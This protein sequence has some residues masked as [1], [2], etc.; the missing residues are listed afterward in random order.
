MKSR[1][2]LAFLV[3]LTLL[4][5]FALAPIN[6]QMKRTTTTTTPTY[7]PPPS[8][9]APSQ[10]Q[11]APVQHNSP[12]PQRE[13][14]SQPS[15][16]APPRQSSPAPSYLAPQRQSSPVPQQQSQP[17]TQQ[18]P[19][20]S[21]SIPT[22]S[23]SSQSHTQ[24]SSNNNNTPQSTATQRQQ[25]AEQQSQQKAQ[26][27]QQEEAAKQQQ[28]Q[29][30]AETQRQQKEQVRQ[31]NEAAKQ[32]QK[33]QKEQAR[34]Q[35]EAMKQQQ[36][37]QKEQ[38]RL[39]NNSPK[40][41][42][43]PQRS[44]A[45][46]PVSNSVPP[47][48]THTVSAYHIPEGGAIGKTATGSTTLSR[49]GSHSVIQQVNSSR[50][51]MS[52]VNRK[53]IPA[54]DVTVH[55][56]GRLTVNVS[57][58]KQYGLRPDGTISSYRDSTRRVS[59]TRS[60]KVSSLRTSNLEVRRSINGQRTVISRRAD[61]TRLISTGAHSGYVERNVVVGNQTYIQR[62]TVINNRIVTNH[63]VG[64]SY[65][66]VTMA[67][68]VTPVFYPP[69]FYGWAFYP[70]ATPIHFAFGWFGA[71]WY[72][73]PDPYFA[74]YQVY[75]GA[76]F[77][78]TDYMIGETLATAYEMRAE[79]ALARN[80]AEAADSGVDASDSTLADADDAD[81]IDTVSSEATTPITPELKAA[82]AEEVKQQLSY[83]S[84][85]N[86]AKAEETG[87]DEVTSVLGRPHQVFLVSSDLEVTATDEQTCSLQ[88]GDIL[89]LQAP[90][91]EG[92]AL[93]ELR[94]ASS[95]RTDCPGGVTVTVAVSDLQEMHNNFRAQV[96]AG[97]GALQAGQGKGGIPVAPPAAVAAPPLP[98]LTGVDT[99]PP[100]KV[101]AM[102][103]AERLQADEAEAEVMQMAF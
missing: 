22:S 51:L 31:Q 99:I 29:Q 42:S 83:D 27:R 8:R 32:Q 63:Y 11:S 33:Q 95:K 92:S 19:A 45:Q 5:L 16:T 101:N 81:P 91:A 58:G 66:G 55:A 90:P 41:A 43:E 70:W 78:L 7:T 15:Y 86:A 36:K 40:P 13:T 93:A 69:A 88:P 37:Q 80:Q 54:G 52:G 79:A 57:G 6:A 71:P 4:N 38:A 46:K 59:F 12:P 39:Q 18:H 74:A 87:Y 21:Y 94:V 60:G 73:G 68:F 77:W 34:Q 10:Y 1:K 67:R 85:A 28:K 103:D 35:K 24:S 30:Q 44:S 20:P 26:A 47:A 25:G 3:V 49:E 50:S 62:T 14:S 96:E 82:I 100:A 76:A 48:Q 65:G 84:A 17:T 9:P 64:F 89:Q 98:T 53:P 56:N 2:N 97:M 72:L 61:N 75:P 23:N 102:L